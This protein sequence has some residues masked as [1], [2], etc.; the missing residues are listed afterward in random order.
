MRMKRATRMARKRLKK[1]AAFL[2][3]G[4]SNRFYEEIY[5]AIWG[6]LADKYNIELSQLNR[7]SVNACLNDKQVPSDQQAQ[8]MKVL[9]DVDL[10]R[11]APGNADAQKQS[12]YDEALMMIA[13]L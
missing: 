5:K 8:I 2:G 10:A 3:S 9:Q 4:D 11:F 12:V 13:G 7:D 6:C 1:A